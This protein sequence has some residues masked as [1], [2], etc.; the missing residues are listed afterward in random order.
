M[1]HFSFIQLF[2]IIFLLYNYT[3]ADE[4]NKPF[5][6]WQRW[7]NMLLP[8]I[9]ITHESGHALVSIICGADSVSIHPF[10]FPPY[11]HHILSDS[12][13]FY[14]FKKAMIYC[15]GFTLTRLTAELI[16]YGLNHSKS[17]RWVEGVGGGFYFINRFDL[18]VQYRWGLSYAI[19]LPGKVF[20]DFSG[21]TN[22]SF[23]NEQPWESIFYVSVG[24][25]IATDLYFNW[26]SLVKNYKRA[27]GK[28]DSDTKDSGSSLNGNVQF[29]AQLIT[30]KF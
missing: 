20:P 19:F 18:Y 17:P 1:R 21:I 9:P 2:L 22:Y 12:V 25:L 28:I 3:N 16:N 14:N 26:N 29:K 30:L 24:V 23:N 27:M 7:T 8:L 4:K 6:A 11:E 13:K 5:P 15:G 10:S